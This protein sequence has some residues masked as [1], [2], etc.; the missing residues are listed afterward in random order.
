MLSDMIEL[1]DTSTNVPNC[2]CR[3]LNPSGMMVRI[4][5]HLMKF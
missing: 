3:E 2:V 4:A 1:I 5:L